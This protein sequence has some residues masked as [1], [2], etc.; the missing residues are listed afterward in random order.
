MQNA[1]FFVVD[2]DPD[3]VHHC[4][5]ALSLAGQHH[6]LKNHTVFSVVII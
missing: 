6:S 1:V 3:L 5:L 4:P 2:D